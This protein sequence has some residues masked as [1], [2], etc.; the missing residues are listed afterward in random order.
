MRSR[1]ERTDRAA[2]SKPVREH[3]VELRV[4]PWDDAGQRLLGLD[5]RI[6]GAPEPASHR[7]CFGNQVHRAALLGAHDALGV[8]MIAEV[9]TL[10]D[11]PFELDQVAPARE[12]DWIGDSLRQA[13][14]LWD[15]VL[16]RSPLTP[17]LASR[18][19]A[20][21]DDGGSRSADS[22]SLPEWRPGIPMLTQVQEAM[23]WVGR[24]F[25]YEPEAGAAPAALDGL[26]GTRSGG[27]ADLAHL[28]ISIVRGWSVPARF[29]TG[30]LD[31][32]YFDPDDE[33]PDP[34]P[35]PQRL[36]CWMEALI[37]GGGWRGFDPAHALLADASYIRL[38]VGR[39]ARDV[40]GFRQSFKGD[41]ALESLTASLRVERLD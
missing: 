12:P 26:L 4:A 29:V 7:D 36:H 9:E 19:I 3:H 5:I 30:Y 2:F 10:F 32:R 39:D 40:T 35:R 31:A 17:D 33:E 22:A 6:E 18:H 8:Q 34:A 38:A 15:F 20:G 21:D 24:Q 14:R 41:G 23:A 28:L 13:P 37:P 25:T 11:N 27:S 1:I 16:H